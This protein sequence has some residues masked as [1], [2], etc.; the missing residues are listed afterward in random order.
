MQEAANK[1][2]QDENLELD[3]D[4]ARIAEEKRAVP[5]P[6]RNTHPLMCNLVP[7]PPPPLANSWSNRCFPA[8]FRNILPPY[9]HA[10]WSER[11]VMTRARREIVGALKSPRLQLKRCLSVEP[12]KRPTFTDLVSHLSDI[13]AISA[14]FHKPSQKGLSDDDGEASLSREDSESSESFTGSAA[15]VHVTDHQSS[16]GS[17]KARSPV[18]RLGPTTSNTLILPRCAPPASPTTRLPVRCG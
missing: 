17:L 13:T 5:K 8:T 2:Q 15:A 9:L 6:P 11:A 16:Q 1:R 18:P 12:A 4:L 3:V 10:V 14:F 7:P